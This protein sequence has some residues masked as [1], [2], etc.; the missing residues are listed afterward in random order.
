M[1]AEDVELNIFIS[2]DRTVIGIVMNSPN[3]KPIS[4]SVLVD[5]LN[6]HVEVLT[7]VQSQ[8]N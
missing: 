1:K 2:Q 6:R 5:I 8:L 7:R 4:N 3:D